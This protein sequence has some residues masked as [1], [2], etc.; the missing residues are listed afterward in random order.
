M[1]A[2]IHTDFKAFVESKHSPEFYQ[3]VLEKAG[4]DANHFEEQIYHNDGEIDKAVNTAAEMLS[5]SRMELL[6]DMGLY[7]APGLIEAF[8]GAIDPQWKTLDLVENVEAHMHTYVRNEMG[9]FPP[10]LKPE[11][12]SE[13]ELK[14]D[15]LSHRKM[16]GLAKGFILGFANVYDESITVDVETS[17]TG[18]SFVIKKTS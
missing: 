5:Q 7:G 17:E 4:F 18:Y 13:N 3:Q 1:H 15:V 9:A 11:R 12:V 8:K 16:A 14:I 2:V 10:A 6:I